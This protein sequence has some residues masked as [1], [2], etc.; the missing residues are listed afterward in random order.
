MGQHEDVRIC[1]CLSSPA[2]PIT[3]VEGYKRTVELCLTLRLFG[4]FFGPSY[5]CLWSCISCQDSHSSWYS[6]GRSRDERQRLL[7]NASYCKIDVEGNQRWYF[8]N[9][10]CH[11]CG[12]NLLRRTSKTDPILRTKFNAGRQPRNKGPT[13]YCHNV[14]L[15]RV[16][17]SQLVR[18][19]SDYGVLVS[20][21]PYC[22]DT[23]FALFTN[24]PSENKLETLLQLRV[25]HVACFFCR[26]HSQFGD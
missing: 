15:F 19:R 3:E 24:W 17:T 13:R 26:A 23:R 12:T 2:H 1:W 8:L 4:S 16:A 18:A 22:S 9:V 21:E 25:R 20:S 10:R 5:R 7:V 11:W 14:L 6:L